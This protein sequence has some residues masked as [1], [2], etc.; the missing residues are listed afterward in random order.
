MLRPLTIRGCCC[1]LLPPVAT[2]IDCVI[3]MGGLPRNK[4]PAGRRMAQGPL[5]G[6]LG[7]I[8]MGSRPSN[9][10][11]IAARILAPCL[12]PGSPLRVP[13]RS[14]GQNYKPPR[15]PLAPDGNTAKSLADGLGSATWRC[16]HFVAPFVTKCPI[17]RRCAWLGRMSRLLSQ[18]V[19]APR[20]S[21]V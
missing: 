8:E 5:R 13:S 21:A 18:R 7:F 17:Y 14:R 10:L 4:W 20:C 3:E 16:S 9:R 19:F 6:S 2:A 1:M 11:L 12:G 15:L